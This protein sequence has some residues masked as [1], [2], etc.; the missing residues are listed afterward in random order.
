MLVFRMFIMLE[1]KV[2][3][4]ILHVFKCKL[5]KSYVWHGSHNVPLFHIYCVR[6]VLT[7]LYKVHVCAVVRTTCPTYFHCHPP[8]FSNHFHTSQIDLDHIELV[9]VSLHIRSAA[10]PTSNT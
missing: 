5:W 8:F 6:M 10:A 1:N 2:K 4:Y 3:H 9:R 7:V